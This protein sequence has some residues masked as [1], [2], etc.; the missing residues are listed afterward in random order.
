[1]GLAS[2]GTAGAWRWDACEAPGS[3]RPGVP[4]AQ[5]ICW[6]DMPAAP[7][8]AGGG[9]WVEVPGGTCAP[10]SSK[11]TKCMGPGL[12]SRALTRPS[13]SSA[14]HS[15]M[16]ILDAG[17]SPVPLCPFTFE[18][19]VACEIWEE[20]GG[21]GWQRPVGA[22]KAHAGPLRAPAPSGKSSW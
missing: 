12:V 10:R 11:I 6:W 2:G 20:H 5:G 21:R 18:K 7:P 4:G 13:V 8:P 15:L 9:T 3:P 1:M 14:L 22:P 19:P 16:N 17:R